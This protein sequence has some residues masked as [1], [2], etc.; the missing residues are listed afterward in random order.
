MKRI[1]LG[2]PHLIK[3]YLI[4]RGSTRKR[5]ISWKNSLRAEYAL[6]GFVRTHLYETLFFRVHGVIRVT[7]IEVIRISL[8]ELLPF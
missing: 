4:H 3:V 5:L 1:L 8:M 6:K 2:F 7:P